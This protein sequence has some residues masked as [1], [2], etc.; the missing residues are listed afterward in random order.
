L[1]EKGRARRKSRRQVGKVLKNGL[2]A[3]DASLGETIRR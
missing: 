1:K 3:A 2:A